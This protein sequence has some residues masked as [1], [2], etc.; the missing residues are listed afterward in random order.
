MSLVVGDQK[1]CSVVPNFYTYILFRQHKILLF[2]HKW[3]KQHC[4]RVLLIAEDPCYVHPIVLILGETMV[5]RSGS[6]SNLKNCT[7]M[8]ISEDPGMAW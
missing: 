4:H 1:L 2:C 3:L 5:G 8:R 6:H 7:P